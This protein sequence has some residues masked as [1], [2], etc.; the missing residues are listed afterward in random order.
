MGLAQW[1][2]QHETKQ[3]QQQQQ[4]FRIF[5]KAQQLSKLGLSSSAKEN[6]LPKFEMKKKKK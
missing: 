4:T 1:L 6:A 3:Q 5:P 2:I